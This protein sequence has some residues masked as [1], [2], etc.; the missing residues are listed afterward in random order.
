MLKRSKALRPIVS[1]SAL[2]TLRLMSFSTRTMSAFRKETDGWERWLAR[3][4]G[5][6]SA[7]VAPHRH[8][9]R[10]LAAPWQHPGARHALRPL[11]PPHTRA[12][13]CQQA[14][15]VERVDEQHRVAAALVL[16]DLNLR[17]DAAPHAQGRGGVNVASCHSYE[18]CEG[19]A[20]VGLW[21]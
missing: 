2:T 6:R 17:L 9:H 8:R 11:P 7:R 21:W 16:P 10:P 3:S 1:T 5:R 12:R 20:G 14:W 19:G 15:P 18:G 4:E 13:T